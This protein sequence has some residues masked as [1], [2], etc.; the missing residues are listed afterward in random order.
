MCQKWKQY[1][2]RFGYPQCCINAFVNRCKNNQYIEPTRIQMRIG[3]HT[4]FIPCSYCC[5]KVLTNQC[6][7]EDLI[8]NRRE[9]NIFPNDNIIYYGN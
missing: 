9:R 8:E 1:G 5:W 7:L 2:K 3:N 4:G 6:K